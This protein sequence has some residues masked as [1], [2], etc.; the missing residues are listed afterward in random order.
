MSYGWE[1]EPSKSKKG[2]YKE[3]PKCGAEMETLFQIPR[4]PRCEKIE[5]EDEEKEK[6]RNWHNEK[7]GAFDVHYVVS[8]INY[9]F[10]VFKI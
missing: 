2:S 6:V 9:I 3:C 10:I 1:S 8:D 5:R 4:C 7:W